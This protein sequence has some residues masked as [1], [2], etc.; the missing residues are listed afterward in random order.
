[1]CST[2]CK[3]QQVGTVLQEGSPSWH[4]CFKSGL[5]GQVRWISLEL[6]AVHVL[7]AVSGHLLRVLSHHL[8]TPG[9]Q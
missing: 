4:A 5:A 7:Q 8:A 2:S 3:Q 6:Q 1:M 9:T